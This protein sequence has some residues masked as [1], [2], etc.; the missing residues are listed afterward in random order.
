MGD[1]YM[2]W[3]KFTIKRLFLGLAFLS[4]AVAA[5]FTLD[6][7]VGPQSEMWQR[8]VY[9]AA[10]FGL[11]ISGLAAMFLGVRGALFGFL[12]VVVF[13]L[14]TALPQVLPEPWNRYCALIY[15]VGLFAWMAYNKNKRK[16]KQKVAQLDSAERPVEPCEGSAIFYESLSGYYYQ[17]I[18][19]DSIIRI[20]RIGNS[21]TGID[22]KKIIQDAVHLPQTKKGDMTFSVDD[23]RSVT[24]KEISGNA[25][26][27]IL[28][29]IKLPQKSLRL[30]ACDT[31]NA[32]KFWS[33]WL[34]NKEAPTTELETAHPVWVRWVNIGTC[35]AAA[36]INLSWLF[37]NVPYTLFAALS[38]F[39]WIFPVGLS[40]V[41]SDYFT[42][43]E[44]SRR[45]QK[46]SLMLILLLSGCAISL[47]T[48]T[49]YNILDWGKYALLSAAAL[50]FLTALYLLLTIRNK[51][52]KRE[53]GYFA[54]VALFA[55][56]GIVGQINCTFD[57][58]QPVSQY[59]VVTELD[60]STSGKGKESYN[61]TVETETGKQLKLETYQEHFE[62]LEVGDRVS[63]H[64]F[65]GVLDIP[66]AFLD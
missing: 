21:F 34:E 57:A 44:E 49:D 23:I 36:G 65:E 52:P 59:A 62:S 2:K 48:L 29:I 3:F 7:F 4:C 35:V 12:A 33:Q 39:A 18:R 28:F 25:D 63:V 42:L 45:S 17:V 40:V 6:G 46:K 15:F 30:F 53:A 13:S 50:I 56:F 60:I 22:S 20:Y 47:R 37:L 1:R 43:L 64:M 24:Y 38:M 54:L 5:G 32:L 51:R 26:F 31:E 9:I 66:Y 16:A 19:K 58:S 11:G 10:V 61:V 14:L 8:L 41:F 27:D 55:V